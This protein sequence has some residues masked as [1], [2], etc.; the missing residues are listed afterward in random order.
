VKIAHVVRSDSF[1]GVERYICLV[2]P[3]LAARG[4]KVTVIGGDQ[5]R[6]RRAADSVQ[7]RPAATTMA[8][9]A[10]LARLGRVDVVHAHMTAAELASVLTKP[11]H[12]ARLVATIHFASPRGS[13]RT[14]RPLRALG[15][16]MDEQIAISQFVAASA[17][18]S[19][20]RILP[21]GVEVAES[22]PSDRERTVLVMQR[23]EVEKQT[24]VVLRAWSASRLRH[25]GWRL[26]IAGRGSDQTDLHR[27]ARELDITES[28]EW[29]GFVEDPARLLSRAAI[30]LA[31]APAEPFGLTVVEAMARA[32]PVVAAD[33]G[34][35]RETVGADGWLFPVGDAGACA[36]ILDDVENRDLPSYGA[37]LQSRQRELF[38]IEDHADG[39]LRIYRELVG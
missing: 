38:D 20:S 37:H 28:V 31:P 10:H 30:F 1:A 32:T 23:L 11:W 13:S 19:A 9:S 12:H 35:H 22:G 17:A 7:W 3:R 5:S 2:A 15:P 14:G 4:C 39:L 25:H 36:R 24:D 27:L 34:A 8:A 6:M 33:G 29:P 18:V 16:L 21:N 26:V